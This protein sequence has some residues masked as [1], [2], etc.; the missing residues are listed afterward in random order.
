MP[1]YAIEHFIL[2]FFVVSIAISCFR[3]RRQKP[4]I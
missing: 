4:V 2:I 1:P 3:Y